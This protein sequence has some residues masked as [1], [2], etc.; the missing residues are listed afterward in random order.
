MPKTS[1]SSDSRAPRSGLIVYLSEGTAVQ[2]QPSLP[3]WQRTSQSQQALLTCWES[4][5]FV[6]LGS[7][8][9]RLL[10]KSLQIRNRWCDAKHDFGKRWFAGI[11]RSL[12]I[13]FFFTSHSQSLVRTSVCKYYHTSVSLP[14]LL[15]V[16][17]LYNHNSPVLIG[18]ELRDSKKILVSFRREVFRGN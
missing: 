13:P 12:F 18:H 9:P 4:V 7:Q 8:C 6:M 14:S 3:C 11:K 10:D 2:S 15:E 17:F 1:I 16:N 5:C